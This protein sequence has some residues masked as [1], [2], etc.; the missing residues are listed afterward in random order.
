MR[1]SLGS[2]TPKAAYLFKLLKIE[3]EI[4]AKK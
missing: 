3:P 1:L 2:K 4:L